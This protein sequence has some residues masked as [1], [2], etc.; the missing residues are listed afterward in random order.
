MNKKNTLTQF[1]AFGLIS[2]L[3]GAAP[4]SHGETMVRAPEIAAFMG[5]TYHKS[6]SVSLEAEIDNSLEV[7]DPIEGFNRAIFD[8]NMAID[9]ILFSPLAELYRFTIPSPARNCVHNTLE[10]LRTPITFT[11]DVLQLEGDRA[12]E[13]LARFLINTTLGIGGLFDVATE[14][15]I[16][17]HK[18]DF[19]QTLAVYGLPSG[20][21]LML[22][23]LGP[24]SVRDL[25]G[26]AFDTYMDP[27]TYGARKWL[28][29]RKARTASYIRTGVDVLDYRERSIEF[30]DGLKK[31]IDPYSTLRSLYG[32]KRK[33]DISNGQEKNDDTP[34][35]DED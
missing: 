33:S 9:K 8:M 20:P 31:T 16:E 3:L 21:Y 10:N 34:R 7:S 6:S 28:G 30:I 26:F 11:N 18:E 4:S 17:P 29:S 1:F 27:T 25:G 2:G 12:M 22:P 13:S 19:G 15:G 32:Q 14:L 35:P 23:I 24:S 5:N